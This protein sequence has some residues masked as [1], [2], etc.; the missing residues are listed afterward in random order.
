MRRCAVPLPSPE[1]LSLSEVVALVKERCDCSE[2]EAKKA[3]RRAGLDGRL[4]AFGSKDLRADDWNSNIDWIAETVGSYFSV[5]IKRA[6]IEEWLGAEQQL[7]TGSLNAATERK[8]LTEPTAVKPIL[9]HD[10]EVDYK[11]WLRKFRADHQRYPTFK[12]DEEWGQSKGLNR[13][14]VRKLRSQLRPQDAKKG[15]A[16]KK[17]HNEKPGQK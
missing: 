15:G 8:P 4:R 9:R 5:S 12:E 7:S 11:E 13:N 6:S 10:T 17:S 2:D 14:R 3:L 16:P 1:S